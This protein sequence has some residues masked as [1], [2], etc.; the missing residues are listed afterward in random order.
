[1]TMTSTDIQ[2]EQTRT[3]IPPVEAR[4]GVISG[5]VLTVLVISLVLGIVALTVAWLVFR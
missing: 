4:Q 1:M 2:R 3:G 5:R